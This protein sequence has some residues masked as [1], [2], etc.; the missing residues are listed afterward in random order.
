M[1]ADPNPRLFSYW[2]DTF[3]EPLEVGPHLRLGDCIVLAV[4]VFGVAPTVRVEVCLAVGRQQRTTSANRGRRPEV[5]DPLECRGRKWH[6]RLTDPAHDLRPVM[7]LRLA[8][9]KAIDH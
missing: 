8:P 2:Q 7:H 1:Q 6:T 9:I 4:A 5:T 3:V